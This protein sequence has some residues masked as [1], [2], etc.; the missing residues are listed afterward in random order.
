MNQ[1]KKKMKLN[2]PLLFA[3]LALLF[4]SV[5]ITRQ[6]SD[7][8]GL[9][10]CLV[11]YSTSVSDSL[12]NEVLCKDEHILQLESELRE[13]EGALAHAE[14]TLLELSLKLKSQASERLSKG[15]NGP[16]ESKNA[17]ADELRAILVSITDPPQ[18]E[19]S[20]PEK[21]V[22]ERKP[23][24]VDESPERH[25]FSGLDLN[26]FSEFDPNTPPIPP[27]PRRYKLFRDVRW[28]ASVGM[29]VNFA[30]RQSG[31]LGGV[32]L[33]TGNAMFG[34]NY[35]FGENVITAQVGWEF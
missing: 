33:R 17:E 23:E 15:Y 27:T 28:G 11:T 21:K 29:G 6:C 14:A 34:V 12:V 25:L 10:D 20:R 30:N 16:V 7:S 32:H 9:P 31:V 26:L 19:I 35:L 4:M 18:G 2:L 5:F 24:K 8:S 3:V 22:T 1:K 13:A